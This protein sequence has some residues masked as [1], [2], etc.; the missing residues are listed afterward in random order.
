[1]KGSYWACGSFTECG[2]SVRGRQSGALLSLLFDVV[3]CF[4]GNLHTIV[5]L[6]EFVLCFRK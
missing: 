3:M 6:F 4:V 5:I 1:M 2:G